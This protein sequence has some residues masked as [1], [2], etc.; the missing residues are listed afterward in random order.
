MRIST[1]SIILF[2]TLLLTGALPIALGE[3]PEVQ[4][5]SVSPLEPTILDDVNISVDLTGPAQ[6]VE[7]EYCV[8]GPGGLCYP[9]VDMNM[10]S[11]THF[12]ILYSQGTFGNNSMAFT[13]IIH[14]TLGV[15]THE[16]ELT[17][18]NV[19]TALSLRELVPVAGTTISLFP[20]QNFTVSG[21]AV[22]DLGE[23][24]SGGNVVMTLG[25]QG[26]V[27][28]V[29]DA[30][31]LFSVDGSFA[32]NGTYT[33]GLTVTDPVHS[34][35]ATASWTAEVSPWP[36]PH[37][38]ISASLAF[39]PMDQPPDAQ[40]NVFYNDSIVVIEYE[41]TNTG[42]G[43]AL[44]VSVLEVISNS[45]YSNTIAVG[46]VTQGWR[47]EGE[48]ELVTSAPGR[49][50]AIVST[51]FDQ[52]API[53]LKAPEP[54]FEIDYEIVGRPIWEGH[55]VLVEMFTQSTCV[56]CVSMEEAIEEV[57]RETE[58]PMEFILYPLDDI[59]SEQKANASGIEATPH[60]LIDSGFRELVGGGDVEDLKADLIS[61]IENGT[62]RI[63]PPI[64]IAMEEDDDFFKITASLPG[65][66]TESTSGTLV[67][68]KVE[69]YS[70]LRNQQGIPM[71]HRYRGELDRVNVIDLAPGGTVHLNLTLPGTGEDILAVFYGPDGTVFQSLMSDHAIDP[72]LYL[73]RSTPYLQISGTET[74]LFNMTMEA[75][76]DDLP[77][78]GYHDGPPFTVST[79]G[80]VQNMD[81]RDGTDR[82]LGPSGIQFDFADFS[83][84]DLPIGRTRHFMSLQFSVTPLEEEDS[85][86]TFKMNVTSRDRTYTMTVVVK[87]TLAPVEEMVISEYH[88]E[89]E[90]RSIFFIATIRNLPEGAIVEG[91]VQPCTSEGVGGLCGVPVYPLLTRVNDTYFRGPVSGLD[92]DS[93]DYL[94]FRLSVEVDGNVISQTEDVKVEISE[95]VDITQDDDDDNDGNGATAAILIGAIAV[96]L[97][98][99]LLLALFLVRRRT[100]NAHD[101]IGQGTQGDEVERTAGEDDTTNMDISDPPTEREEGPSEGPEGQ[102]HEVSGPEESDLDRTG[103][104]SE[105]VV[106][107]KAEVNAPAKDHDT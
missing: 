4:T 34:I 79:Q 99:M 21:R 64:A 83:S 41:V 76:R 70:N 14:H 63:T 30:D 105:E 38:D 57:Y 100:M 101:A 17:V 18:R 69:T 88:L 71:M 59:E 97:V 89:G 94:T 72:V 78:S 107:T 93:Y 42:T 10:T 52:S 54:S 33:V 39:D 46:N 3:G 98:L 40:G 47:H 25:E 104:G 26:W 87:L 29:T 22:N 9:P 8:T 86:R 16:F 102:D 50:R 44:N 19:P 60:V 24:L 82:P 80:T 77:T 27:G 62:R 1:I 36:L 92:L 31:G 49:Y 6:R 95:L 66:Y 74:V 2:F 13:M 48:L 58:L 51:V 35:N 61:A 23:N 75:F 55:T 12:W 15:N 84:A 85:T 68:M 81:I 43:E 91:R 28:T 20:D 11:D 37:M 53:E 45:T 32:A 106:P 103:M 56:P 90:G 73:K 67:A 65:L 96:W 7:I 5:L